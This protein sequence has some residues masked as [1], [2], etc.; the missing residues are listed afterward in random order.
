M[1]V[2]CA[3]IGFNAEHPI[4]GSLIIVAD[5]AAAKSAEHARIV[6]VGHVANKADIGLAGFRAEEATD[7][8]AGP[9]PPAPP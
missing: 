2:G 1:Q 6:A 7:I 4:I 8:E 5:L 9:L 3:D